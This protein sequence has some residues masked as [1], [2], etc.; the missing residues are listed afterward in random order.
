MRALR[1]AERMVELM[2][3]SPQ[4]QQMM[5]GVMPA[6][7]RNPEVLKQLFG[8]PSMR[9]RIAEM[10]ASRG[11]TIPDHLLERMSPSSMDD[12]FARAQRLGLDPGALF[13][14]LM[15]H[16]GLLAALQQPR[17]MA[18]FLDIAEDPSR[19]SKYEHDKELLDVVFKVREVMGSAKPSTPSSGS[20]S[21]RGSTIPVTSTLSAAPQAQPPAADAAPGP[22]PPQPPPPGQPPRNAAEASPS[23]A[24]SGSTSSGSD[25][26]EPSS[27]ATEGTSTGGGSGSS[28]ASSAGLNPLV[29]LMS[30][31]PKAA[32]WL[33]NPK[34]MAALQEV[35][36]SPWKTVKYIFDRDV[37]E[38]FQD[39]KKL[40]RGHKL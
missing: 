30:S 6:P 27:S 28:S 29:V 5:L 14:K 31:D 1:K 19:Q 21:A 32:R 36:K 7:M 20:T 26:A 2:G 10:I 22:A 17:V 24:S 23:S 33:Q 25:A 38:A 34:V 35:H 12:T 16:P 13:T 8:D 11:L 9:R 18:A 4:L 15:S 39:L 37:M 3:Q 40:L